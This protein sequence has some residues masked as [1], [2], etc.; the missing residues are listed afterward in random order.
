MPVK[1]AFSR[2]DF[3]FDYSQELG[4]DTLAASEWSADEGLT[5][6]GASFDDTST[7]VWI[8]GGVEGD[9]LTAVNSVTTQ[10]G[11]HYDRVLTLIIRAVVDPDDDYLAI[12][13]DM[14]RDLAPPPDPLPVPDTY[15]PRAARA[16]RLLLRYLSSTDGGVFKSKSISGAVA[17]SYNDDTQVR[18]I[19]A[20]SMGDYFKGS[21][22]GS[23]STGYISTFPIG[24]G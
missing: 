12:A 23:S 3:G 21:D 7:S 15:S 16:E 10:A 24:R 4:G 2:R 19:V 14:V 8:E 20:A 11:R 5:L 22:S 18:K 1:E 9:I 6:S 17:F 13:S